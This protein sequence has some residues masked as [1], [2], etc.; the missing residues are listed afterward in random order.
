MLLMISRKNRGATMTSETGT[1]I[2]ADG[3]DMTAILQQLEAA[4]EANDHRAFL[5]QIE[6]VDWSAHTPSDLL[7][8]IQLALSLNLVW[9]ARDLAKQ[10]IQLF[11][12]DEPLRR[13]A[14]VFEPPTARMSRNNTPLKGIK[15]SHNW[16]R[17]HAHEYRGQWI[18]VNQ[19]RLLGAARTLDELRPIIDQAEDSRSTIVTKV[20]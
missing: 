15:E 18:A 1:T 4:V 14:R 7:C 10:G 2:I 16:L 20:L 9:P 8:A 13:A 12:D 19:G 3:S 11:P 5:A 6:G 17:D